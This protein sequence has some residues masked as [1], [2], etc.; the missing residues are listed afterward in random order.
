MRRQEGCSG[1]DVAD[2]FTSSNGLVSL[3]QLSQTSLTTRS[4]VTW[5]GH[6]GF[7]RT[8]STARLRTHSWWEPEDQVSDFAGKCRREEPTWCCFE[9]ETNPRITSRLHLQSPLRL[10]ARIFTKGGGQCPDHGALYVNRRATGRIPRY[11]RDAGDC[12]SRP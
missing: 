9:N 7:A 1:C 5:S 10:L 4:A 3:K 8:D 2:W 12:S 6:A 11:R